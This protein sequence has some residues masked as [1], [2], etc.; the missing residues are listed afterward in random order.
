MEVDEA[1]YE[2]LKSKPVLTEDNE[3]NS[4]ITTLQVKPAGKQAMS[5]EDYKHGYLS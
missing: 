3:L 5:R 2:K 1:T 4:A